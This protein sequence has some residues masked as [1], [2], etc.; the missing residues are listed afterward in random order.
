MASGWVGRQGTKYF[1]SRVIECA[2]SGEATAV[3]T[4]LTSIN[5]PLLGWVANAMEENS[6]REDLRVNA[7]NYSHM[8]D[9]Q[10]AVAII[11]ARA[12]HSCGRLF[13]SRIRS[14]DS[15]GDLPSS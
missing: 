14:Q 3:D 4:R 11:I 7:W 6:A 12:H 9:A 10:A 1:V 2:E 5:L 8:S 15:R 13:T